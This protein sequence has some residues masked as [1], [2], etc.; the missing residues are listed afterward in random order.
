MA[1]RYER[2]PLPLNRFRQLL[3]EAK[4]KIE[5][6]LKVKRRMQV[7]VAVPTF[8]TP[9]RNLEEI[10]SVSNCSNPEVDVR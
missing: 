1:P 5:S 8:R 7:G 6:E 10:A 3:D 2:C 9:V 4:S